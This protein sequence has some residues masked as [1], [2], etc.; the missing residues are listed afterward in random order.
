M[1]LDVLL[2]CA[3]EVCSLRILFAEVFVMFGELGDGGSHF[4]V[5]T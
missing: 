1:M 5:Y 2:L 4:I 3:E